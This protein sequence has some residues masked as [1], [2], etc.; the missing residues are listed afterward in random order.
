MRTS[1]G[2]WIPMDSPTVHWNGPNDQI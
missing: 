2:K 1:G